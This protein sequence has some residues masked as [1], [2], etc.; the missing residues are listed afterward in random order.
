MLVILTKADK[1]VKAKKLPEEIA[2]YLSSDPYRHLKQMRRSEIETPFDEYEYSQEMRRI[3][4]MLKNYVMDDVPDG[5][6]LI[7]R[8]KAKQMNIEF[9]LTSSTGG[10]VSGE[11]ELTRFRVLDPFLWTLMLSGNVADTGKENVVVLLVDS[12]TSHLHKSQKLA[13]IYDALS[14]QR[15][16]I[17]TYYMGNLKPAFIGERPEAPPKKSQPHFVGVVLD[18]LNVHKTYALIITERVIY[19]LHDYIHSAWH[20]RLFVLAPADIDVMWHHKM[21]SVPAL[22]D[23]YDLADA[24]FTLI[25]DKD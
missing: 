7:N 15:V 9:C 6:P 3:S 17:T 8:I 21:E 14:A 1:L 22:V 11:T 2:K 4:Q 5:L 23:S 13:A 10:E 16:H 18:Q 19:D 24:F 12:D 25:P 20:D